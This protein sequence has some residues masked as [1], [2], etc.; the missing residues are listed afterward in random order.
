VTY[1]SLNDPEFM[2]VA[3]DHIPA[4]RQLHDEFDVSRAE[5]PL[6]ARIM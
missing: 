6:V 3:H 5:E 2:K 1:E 4:L